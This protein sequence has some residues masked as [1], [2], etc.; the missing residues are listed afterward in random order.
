MELKQYITI[1]VKKSDSNFA[2]QMPNGSTYGNA[3]D[4]AYDILQK[5]HELSQQSSQSLK[6]AIDPVVVE[7]GD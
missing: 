6:P 7:E 4:A 3:I 2:F 1:E 5:L